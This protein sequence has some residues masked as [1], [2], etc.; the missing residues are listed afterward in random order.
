MPTPGF[1]AE[2]TLYRTAGHY[3]ATARGRAANPGTL[4]AP[5]SSCC[6][7]VACKDCPAGYWCGIVGGT[8]WC[9][10]P[11]HAAETT[12]P[13]FLMAKGHYPWPYHCVSGDGHA[14]IYCHT[15]CVATPVDVACVGPGPW[16]AAETEPPTILK[17]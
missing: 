8:A 10:K 4:V 2:R 6:D 5:A 1:T 9:F 16:G 3:R 14:E 15:G 11:T 17:A 7:A 13:R 12:E